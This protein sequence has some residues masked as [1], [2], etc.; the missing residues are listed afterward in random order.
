MSKLRRYF[1]EGDYCFITCVTFQRKPILVENIDLLMKSLDKAMVKAE[2]ELIA[3]VVLPDHFHALMNSGTVT[4]TNIV[5]RMKLSFSTN[6]RKR[7]NIHSGSIWQHRYWD[8]II[9]N[10]E[11]LNKHID[12]IHINP[13]KHG[14]VRAPIDYPHSSFR[15][16]VKKELYEPDWGMIL[17]EF[18]GDFGE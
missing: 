4:V 1:K 16:F 12:Y 3:W 17:P 6:L 5:H 8:H 10:E 18:E 11:D 7:H 15:E 9:R 14:L 2:G 13:V